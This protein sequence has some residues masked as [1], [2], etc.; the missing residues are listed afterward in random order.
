MIAQ[1]FSRQSSGRTME[2]NKEFRR[3]VAHFNSG[4]FFESH[5]IWEALW[6]T[7]SGI[8]KAFL[9]G[10][11]QAAA[12]F[13]HHSRGNSRGMKSLLAAGLAKLDHFPEVHRGIAVEKLRQDARE[14]VGNDGSG[15]PPR[16]QFA[17]GAGPKRRKVAR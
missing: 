9:Q 6:L 8:E 5:E 4:K 17:Q 1:E 12:A 14:W 2:E 7:A 3:G 10:L 16:I 11:I 13:Y 15:R